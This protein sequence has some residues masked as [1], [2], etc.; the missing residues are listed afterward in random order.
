MIGL[1]RVRALINDSL[2]G[3]IPVNEIE[4]NIIQTP[5]F[6]R[7][8]N[9]RQL[10]PTY[11]IYPGA[12]H[13]RFEHSLGVMHLSSRM[14]ENLLTT[15]DVDELTDIFSGESCDLI[16]RLYSNGVYSKIYYPS[17]NDLLRAFLIQSVRLAGLLH[18][19]GH[20]PYSHV[21][22]DALG[23]RGLHER[24]TWKLIISWNELRD[25]LRETTFDLCGSMVTGITPEHIVA[26]LMDKEHR[27]EFLSNNKGYIPLLSMQGYELLHKIISGVFDADRLDYLRR[28]ACH[29]GIVYGLVDIDRIIENMGV[30]RKNNTYTIY[31]DLKA[32][33]ALEDMLSSRIKM[34]R[35]VYYHH[36][37]IVLA[38]ITRRMVYEALKIGG[39]NNIYKEILLDRIVETILKYPW[40]ITDDLLIDIA[41]YLLKHSRKGSKG[42][43]YAY[44]F[45]NR[46]ALP[47]TLF[48]REEDLYHYIRSIF[49]KEIDLHSY[50]V[51]INKLSKY[52]DEL[53]EYIRV[54]TNGE[55]ELLTSL[56]EY[57]GVSPKKILIKVGNGLREITELSYYIKWL[58]EQ[59]RDYRHIYMYMYTTDPKKMVIYKRSY[60]ERREAINKIRDLLRK[61]IIEKLSSTL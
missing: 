37:N 46:E 2:Y 15:L 56:I 35:L 14:L 60:L 8:H 9:I 32:L 24:I 19:L 28:D 6:N 44:A 27:I 21:L 54:E 25:L 49:N 43:Y 29:T 48:K 52:L 23:E 41:E 17:L 45:L 58:E 55:F 40:K 7:L 22:E 5:V 57:H 11:L 4:Y 51:L 38:E 20:Y 1:S 3:S 59:Y 34:Y 50:K 61:Y 16:T 47:I 18:D 30:I 12:K 53:E 31:Y 13:S 26:I 33:P 39:N 42:Y 36:K 10:G